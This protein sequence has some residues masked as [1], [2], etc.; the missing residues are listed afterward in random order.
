MVPGTKEH[1]EKRC[2]LFFLKLKEAVSSG[3]TAA[4]SRGTSDWNSPRHLSDSEEGVH[5]GHPWGS[6]A[7]FSEHFKAGMSYW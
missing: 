2:L 6:Q 7:T 5:G 3:R 1:I 4:T